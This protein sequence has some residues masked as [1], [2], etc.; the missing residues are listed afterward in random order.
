MGI[1]SFFV[2][3]NFALNKK[4]KIVNYRY[5][6]ENIKTPV[7]IVVLTDLHNNLYG[8]KQEELI[9]PIKEIN[10]DLIL[11]VGDLFEVNNGTENTRYLLE[12]V[13]ANYPSYFVTGNHEYY[14][15]EVNT[16]KNIVESY[17]IQ[18]LDG[19]VDLLEIGDTQL[20]IGG[21]DD[22]KHSSN[23]PYQLRQ[24]SESYDSTLDS[25]NILLSHRPEIFNDFKD[26]PIDL[27]LSGH[28][29]GGQVRIPFILNG[30]FSPDQG[31]FP[32]YAGGEYHLEDRQLVVSR[33]LIFQNQ[34]PRIFNRP[35]LVTIVLSE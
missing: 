35:E 17:Q 23:Y 34:L 20:Q 4:L 10:P 25:Y 24:L 28:A 22:G 8:K 9:K 14:T 3:A 2:F 18:V 11:L 26:L 6:H 27:I 21:I 1:L 32:K 7:K 13:G 33:G 16:L 30:L 31:F 29:H 5:H 12:W 19:K 15:K